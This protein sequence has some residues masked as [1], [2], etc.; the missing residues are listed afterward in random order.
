MVWCLVASCM[1]WQ[2]VAGYMVWQLVADCMLRQPVTHCAV[3]LLMVSGVM[4][5]LMGVTGDVVWESILF[6][7]VLWFMVI[8]A[9]MMNSVFQVISDTRCSIRN[10][11]PMSRVRVIWVMKCV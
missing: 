10:W 9:I 3:L 1:V 6:C 8:V 4:E 2:L 7:V 5:F 11:L